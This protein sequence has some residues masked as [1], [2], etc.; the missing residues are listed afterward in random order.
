M[1]KVFPAD[2][3]SRRRH[4]RRRRPGHGDGEAVPAPARALR[5]GRGRRALSLEGKANQLSA[6]GAQQPAGGHAGPRRR[7]ALRRLRHCAA[8]PGRL[9]Q[10]DVTGGRYEETDFAATGSGSLHAG[11]VDQ[12]RLPRRPRPRGRRSTSPSPRC[13]RP[14]TRTRAT[15]GPDLVRGIYPTMATITADGLRAGRPTTRSPSASARLR[16]PAVRRP[17]AP[18]TAGAA[19][20]DDGGDA[21]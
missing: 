11:T 19:P 17:R 14:P 2:R 10:Y 9:F 16:R 7:A 4:R 18:P 15:G 6:D 12:A 1:E 8:A 20:D 21:R 3:H 5:E 13:S